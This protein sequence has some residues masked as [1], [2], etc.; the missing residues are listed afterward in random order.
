MIET[1]YFDD[2]VDEHA[3]NTNY[4]RGEKTLD[5]YWY[6]FSNLFPKEY[7]QTSDAIYWT[8]TDG[9]FVFAVGNSDPN[10]MHL[11]FS[12]RVPEYYTD[13]R[14]FLMHE[15]GHVLTLNTTQVNN[16]SLCE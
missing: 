7:R 12:D 10:S 3:H 1:D 4:N 5:E 11:L 15:F 6:V 2:Y 9:Y 8:D 16:S 13:F 14:Y